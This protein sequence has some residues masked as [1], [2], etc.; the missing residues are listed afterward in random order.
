MKNWTLTFWG[1]H[2]ASARVSRGQS[3]STHLKQD[4]LINKRDKS[5]SKNYYQLQKANQRK[6][7]LLFFMSQDLFCKWCDRLT[8]WHSDLSVL[9][10]PKRV[11]DYCDDCLFIH[12][13]GHS[14]LAACAWGRWKITYIEL[15]TIFHGLA[16]SIWQGKDSM[17]VRIPLIL[18]PTS[19]SSSLQF[20]LSSFFF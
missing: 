7:Y 9:C 3:D 16:T 6:C 15:V 14:F 12:C 20:F 4:R 1:Y 18:K 19:S 13:L 11:E 17:N 10:V 8:K 5:Y 2:R